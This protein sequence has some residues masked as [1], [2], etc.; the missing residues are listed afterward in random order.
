M[1]TLAHR[2][3]ELRKKIGGHR[4]QTRHED[5]RFRSPEEMQNITPFGKAIFRI[6][7]QMEFALRLNEANNHRFD[8]PIDRAITLLESA[9]DA[10]GTLT[11]SV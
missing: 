6:T 10:E 11:R 1:S 5:L 7:G 3:A 2:Y 4:E 9:M 8:E